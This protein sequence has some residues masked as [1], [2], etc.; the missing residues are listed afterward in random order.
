MFKLIKSL[1][2][3]YKE[4]REE[5]AQDA[6]DFQRAVEE[7]NLAF[8]RKMAKRKIQDEKLLANKVIFNKD[9]GEYEFSVMV[10]YEGVPRTFS[11][12]GKSEEACRDIAGFTL[13]RAHLYKETGACS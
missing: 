4:Y 12:Q 2:N 9:T 11:C 1:I 7:N 5:K 3:E 13:I 6:L 8:E 10:K